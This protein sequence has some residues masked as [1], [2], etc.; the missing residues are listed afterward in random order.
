MSSKKYIEA[1]EFLNNVP[2]FTTKNPLE[3]TRGFYEF[4]QSISNS[5]CCEEKLG[6]IIHVAGTNGKGSVCAFMQSICRQSG[7]RTA[8]FIS[9][10][11]ITTRERFVIDGEIITEDEFI[12]A[13]DWLNDMIEEYDKP[14]MPTYFERLFFMGF[15]IFTK[16]KPDVT[17][18]ETGLGG[19]LDTTNI[20]KK[21][22]VTVIT[23]IGYDHMAYLGDTLE[24]IAGEKAGII[25][26]NVPVVF[27]DRKEAVSRVLEGKSR[28]LGVKYYPVSKKDYKIKEIKKKSIDFSVTNLYDNYVSLIIN[29]TALYQVENAGVAYRTSEVLR[30]EGGLD[31]IT[32][33]SIAE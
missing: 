32:D 20:I 24:K 29:T 17:I 25:K 6:R 21:P 15:Y 3:A 33:S 28:E 12:E 22:A 18:L 5:E 30:N 9:P 10:H 26:A 13:F 2:R 31:R 16:A 8:M 1:E 7:Y 4:I 23:E 14:Y 19:R 27:S 11:L